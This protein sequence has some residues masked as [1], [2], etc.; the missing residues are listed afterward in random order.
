MR[1]VDLNHWK[2]FMPKNLY[3]YVVAASF[4]LCTPISFA[5]DKAPEQST[6]LASE[7]KKPLWELGVGLGGLR[8]PAYIGASQNTQRLL[9]IPYVIYR[10]EIFRADENGIGARLLSGDNYDIDFSLGAGLGGGNQTIDLRKGMPKLGP[11][12]EIG[13]RLSWRVAQPSKDSMV[14]VNFP[15]RAVFEFNN[16]IKNRGFVFEPNVRYTN[17]NIG[18]GI[19]FVAQAGLL[20]GDEKIHKH[21]YEVLPVYA[22]VGRPVFTSKNG[23]LATRF[24]VAAFKDVTPNLSVGAFAR[25]DLS[26]NS[27]SEKSSLHAKNNGLTV[28]FGLNY[29]FAKSSTLVNW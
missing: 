24:S 13:P 12:F 5:Q 28:G 17:E 4:A 14:Q 26:G 9:P 10:G 6:P 18:A 7:S 25:M 2:K 16:G 1:S 22:T 21:Y 3:H 15:L 23:L 11:T 19:G 8:S 29:T 20:W 27:A